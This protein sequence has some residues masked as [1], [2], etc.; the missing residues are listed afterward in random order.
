MLFEEFLIPRSHFLL[1]FCR[2]KK[3]QLWWVHTLEMQKNLVYLRGEKILF[4]LKKF[5]S[6]IDR[7]TVV[8]V[9]R[10]NV[11]LLEKVSICT[12]QHLTKELLLTFRNASAEVRRPSTSNRYDPRFAIL[13]VKHPTS[14]MVWGC[15]SASNGRG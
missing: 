13:I 4:L 1:A 7:I 6:V 9:K 12:I 8:T 14:V 15:F 2:N 10:E 11:Y 5:V 3:N